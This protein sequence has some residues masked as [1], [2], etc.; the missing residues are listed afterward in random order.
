M[1]ESL[2]LSNIP[3]LAQ[4]PDA[5]KVFDKQRSL[6]TSHQLNLGDSRDLSVLP[7]ESL[8]LAVTSPPY[9]I[10]KEYPPREGQLGLIEDYE[11]FHDELS[12]VWQEVHRVLVP[13][14]RLIC[15]VGD[16]C[17]SRRKFGRHVVFPLH[18]DITVR[19]RKIGFDNLAPIIWYKIANAQY[20][21]N[22]RS[23]ILGK[24][25][26]PNAVVKNDIEFILML[27]KP[28]A[29]R[30]P[31]DEQ[32]LLSLIPRKF[33]EQWFRQIWD[34]RGES[35]KNHP[36]PF[37]LELAQRL[38]RMYSFVG[39]TVLDPFAGS[40]T[41]MLAALET[42]RNSVGFEIDPDFFAYAKNRIGKSAMSLDRKAD[43]KATRSK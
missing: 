40:G 35:T 10:L 33:H 4:Q 15:V 16:V 11:K 24:P 20:E 7:N 3:R 43:F 9:W 1:R 31:S 25:Y 8:H 19:C 30:N 39:D 21:A 38:V 41:T 36:A 37:P 2:S 34:I 26:E 32:R 17:L 5:E 22:T 23:T 12:K 14:G 28:G 13:G 18:S 29:Y 27:R 6:P 42:G